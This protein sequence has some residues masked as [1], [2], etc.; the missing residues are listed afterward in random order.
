M[1][2]F[3]GSAIPSAAI[4]DYTIGNSLR[5]N[6]GDSPRLSRS[7]SGGS[8]RIFT[9]STWIKHTEVASE[10]IWGAWQGTLSDANWQGLAWTSDN[11]LQFLT[12]NGGTSLKTTP[13]YRD[14]SAWYHVVLAVDTNQSVAADRVKF[15]VNGEQVTDFATSTYPT[16]DFDYDAVAGGEITIGTN[17]NGSAYYGWMDGYFAD[18][19][20]IDGTQYTASD[21]GRTNSDTNQWIPKD[22]SGLTFGTNGFYQKY[23]STELANSFADSSLPTSWTA[24]E[25]ITSVDYLVVGGGG[26]GGG[27]VNEPSTGYT[28]GGGGGAGGMLTGTLTVVPGTV[29]TVTI[30]GGGAAGYNSIGGNGSDSVF[31]TITATGGGGGGRAKAR[32]DEGGSGGGS[33]ST[34]GSGKNGVAGQGSAGGSSAAWGGGGGGG[35][36]AVGTNGSGGAH[37]GAG[38]AGTASSISGAS[39]TYAGGGGGGGTAGDNNAAGGSGGGGQGGSYDDNDAADGTANT[40]GGGGGAGGENATALYG[41]AGGSGIV[42]LDD[43][44]TVTSFTSSRSAHTITAN[45]NV[46]NTRAVRKIGDS[47]IKF[48]GNGDYLSVP[49][50]SDWDIGTG[51]FTMECWCNASN[52]ETTTQVYLWDIR[53]SGGNRLTCASNAAGTNGIWPGTGWGNLTGWAFPASTWFHVAVVRQSGT[54][55]IYLDGVQKDTLGS[56]TTDFDGSWTFHIGDK[57]DN[58]ADSEINGYLDEIRFSNTCRYDDGTTFTP[59]TTEFTADANTLLLI[60]SNWTGGLGADSSGNYN[61]FTPTNLAATDQMIDTPTNNWCTLNPLIPPYND[62]TTFSEG[63]LKIVTGTNSLTNVM[64]T[65]ST[66]ATGKWY[67]EFLM[68]DSNARQAVGATSDLNASASANYTSGNNLWTLSGSRDFMYAGQSGY[69][70]INNT[71]DASYGDAFS[72][73]DIIAIALNLDD[74][75]VNFYR[76]NVA[77]GVESI[78]ATAPNGYVIGLSNISSGYSMT[79]AANFGQDSSFAGEKT[80]QGNQDANELGDFYYAPPTGYLAVCTSNLPDPEIALPGDH[81]NTILYDDGAGAKTGVG[82]QPDL[83]LFKSRGSA[84]DF[85]FVDAVR[86]LYWSVMSPNQAVQ[87]EDTTGLTAFGA[88]G[89][90]VGADT[91]YSDT[92]GDGM[93]AWSWKG[94]GVSGGTLNENGNRDSQVNVNTTAGFSIVTWENNNTTGA[95]VGHGLSQAPDM[96]LNKTTTGTY[97]WYCYHSG[98]DATAPEDYYI[99]LNTTTARTDN[100]ADG[101]NDTAPT[102]TIFT[103]GAEGTNSVGGMDVVS[104]CFHNVDGYSKIGSFAGNDVADG[105]CIYTGFKPAFLLLRK[106][107]AI[108]SWY[109]LDNKR[110]PFNQV[111]ND[112]QTNVTDAEATSANF[113]DFLSNGFKMRT[114]GGAVNSGTLIYAAFAESPFKYSNA[115]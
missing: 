87:I 96:I 50:S 32:G 57:Y 26:G 7:V 33:G 83:V 12:W 93:V 31:A 4:D 105:P 85:K 5:Y 51:D 22:A 78:P 41:G 3:P 27:T 44:T 88:D 11:E 71:Y 66:G 10:Q 92:T 110:N 6:S 63:N 89:F 16:E 86:G 45:G 9:V 36:S 13:V 98:L 82:F 65:M 28:A 84:Y 38:G 79:V 29:Y 42:I 54:G 20:F 74:Q 23:G 73:G 77:Q 2:I 99:N 34:G 102:A 100:A 25:G 67:A 101:W 58:A 35:K 107:T 47:S 56:W 1:A 95:T 64:G 72:N 61:A 62:P 80:A 8:K 24:P 39:V 115:R 14:P 108:A 104:Y 97:G 48:D 49:D 40:G 30:G 69:W 114:S 53:E 46:T 17:W 76:N 70:Q 68:L 60:H 15:F 18:F 81:F 52:L 90:T 19:Y 109:V 113:V 112:L 111:L 91:D 59:Q 37:G 103:L 55:R 94:N 21:F 43:G 106:S 75:E